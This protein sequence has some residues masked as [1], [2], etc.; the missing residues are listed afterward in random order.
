[1]QQHRLAGHTVLSM[2]GEAAGA[3]SGTSAAQHESARSPR[4]LACRFFIGQWKMAGFLNEERPVRTLR[5][6]IG[7][8]ERVYCGSIGYEVRAPSVTVSPPR[9]HL[10]AVC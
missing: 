4:Q 6:I 8:L 10:P 2:E 7:N 1:M 3:A 5:D 9:V